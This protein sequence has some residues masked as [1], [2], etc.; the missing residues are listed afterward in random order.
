MEIVCARVT[1]NDGVQTYFVGV[2]SKVILEAGA[3]G[4]HDLKYEAISLAEAEKLPFA[5]ISRSIS[6]VVRGEHHVC[7]LGSQ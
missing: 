7:V 3:A 6:R 2:N 1:R 5:N 4:A